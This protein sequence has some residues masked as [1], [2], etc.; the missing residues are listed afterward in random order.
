MA[1][2]ESDEIDVVYKPPPENHIEILIHITDPNVAGGRFTV[3][4]AMGPGGTKTLI[5]KLQAAFEQ[6]WVEKDQS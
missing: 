1:Q 2:Y 6:G 4:L 3:R 5:R